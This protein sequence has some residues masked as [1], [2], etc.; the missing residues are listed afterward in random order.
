MLL[1]AHVILPSQENVLRLTLNA[2]D[3]CVSRCAS[4]NISSMN[5]YIYGAS[6]SKANGSIY[7]ADFSCV[8]TSRCEVSRKEVL[9]THANTFRRGRGVLTFGGSVV[10]LHYSVKSTHYA[11]FESI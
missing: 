10:I 1:A 8:R 11:M 6:K 4:G 7:T 3:H 9:W 2:V 5:I